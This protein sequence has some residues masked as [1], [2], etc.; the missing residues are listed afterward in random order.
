MYQ[1]NINLSFTTINLD[2]GNQKVVFAG[3][4]A[5]VE[6]LRDVLWNRDP[7]PTISSVKS[8]VSSLVFEVVS[9]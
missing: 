8:Y 9:S 5:V 2:N 1:W 6:L 3:N 7:E 4:F